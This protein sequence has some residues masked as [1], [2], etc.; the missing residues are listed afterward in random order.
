MSSF[1]D[2]CRPLGRAGDKYLWKCPKDNS[3]DALEMDCL[4]DGLEAIDDPHTI[5]I[6]T[7]TPLPRFAK[8]IRDTLDRIA[9]EVLED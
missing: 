7:D 4:F 9:S 8:P 6:L 1:W 3:S 2:R 5:W